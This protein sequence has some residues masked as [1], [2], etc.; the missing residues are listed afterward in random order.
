MW[1]GSALFAV[2]VVP[3]LRA[4]P[5]LYRPERYR[6]LFC[7]LAWLTPSGTNAVPT[8]IAPPSSCSFKSPSKG[9][10]PIKSVFD[11]GGEL[12]TLNSRREVESPVSRTRRRLLQLDAVGI[13]HAQTSSADIASTHCCFGEF[14]S[15]LRAART[16]LARNLRAVARRPSALLSVH[17]SCNLGHQ[18]QSFCPTHSCEKASGKVTLIH[19]KSLT[20]LRGAAGT[21][22]ANSQREP[23][24]SGSSLS[25]DIASRTESQMTR[26]STTG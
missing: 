23:C 21:A 24:W 13:E 12:T 6:G 9:N 2:R 19:K 4:V 5:V 20:S 11:Q 3:C 7:L 22:S 15:A 17:G 14:G 10:T 16:L 8:F 1:P 25:H 18:D 26:S